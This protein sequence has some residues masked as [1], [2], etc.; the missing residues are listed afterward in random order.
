MPNFKMKPGSK[1]KDTPGGFNQKQTHTISKLANAPRI[2]I[3]RKKQAQ[4]TI[5]SASS[6]IK[7][8]N[9]IMARKLETQK[10]GGF[11]TSN[12]RLYNQNIKSRNR[13]QR[14]QS[15]L[16]GTKVGPKKRKLGPGN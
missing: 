4:K 1:Q 9:D 11:A 13:R 2:G 5:D 7:R 6:A 15:I 16:Y 8:N 14:A 10:K 12:E 3:G